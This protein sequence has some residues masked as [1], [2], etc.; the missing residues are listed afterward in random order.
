MSGYG[1]FEAFK[2]G[3]LG[4]KR[5]HGC[6]PAV[7]I[8][9]GISSPKRTSPLSKPIKFAFFPST[10]KAKQVHATTARTCLDRRMF[11]MQLIFGLPFFDI[12]IRTKNVVSTVDE[13]LASCV[14]IQPAR[15][16]VVRQCHAFAFNNRIWMWDSGN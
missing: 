5:S 9:E 1:A 11:H 12:F 7:R 4:S 2:I 16:I 14:V 10:Q 15:F 6:S 8:S 13:M 3:D